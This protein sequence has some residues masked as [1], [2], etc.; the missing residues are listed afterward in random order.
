MSISSLSGLIFVS[1]QTTVER[2]SN[3]WLKSSLSLNSNLSSTNAG[4]DSVTKYSVRELSRVLTGQVKPTPQSLIRIQRAIEAFRKEEQE[5]KEILS[6]AK[7]ISR[8][9][10]L[11]KFATLAGVDA[12]NLSHCL[13]GNR[14]LSPSLLD[15]I[16]IAVMKFDQTEA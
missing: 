15:K 2:Y 9:I 14:N 11:R 7:A 4:S 6:K 10:G 1:Q 3:G 5:K 13:S 16:Q 8:Q 12:A